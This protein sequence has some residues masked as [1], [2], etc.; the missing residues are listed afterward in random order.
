M[1]VLQPLLQSIGFVIVSTDSGA[2]PSPL[3]EADSPYAWYRLV[4]SLLISMIGGVG[5][6]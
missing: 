1:P 4:M 3:G 6:W 2:A 5:L